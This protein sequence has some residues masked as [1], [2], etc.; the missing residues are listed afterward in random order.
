[1]NVLKDL[2]HF[3]LGHLC[4]ELPLKLFFVSCQ[5]LHSFLNKFES[6]FY[7]VGSAG[8]H[9]QWRLFASFLFQ[10]S[11]C[12]CP[13]FSFV[14]T[15]FPSYRYNMLWWCYMMFFKEATSFFNRFI[16]SSNFFFVCFA[17]FHLRRLILLRLRIMVY[18]DHVF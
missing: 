15:V 13:G 4:I 10:F 14:V 1:M 12:C 18:C 6:I 5:C 3:R 7:L 2:L 17:C 16:S 8:L 11:Y 9:L